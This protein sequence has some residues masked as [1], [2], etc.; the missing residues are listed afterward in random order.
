MIYRT[1]VNYEGEMPQPNSMK[2]KTSN[3]S[4]VSV[5]YTTDRETIE[6][7]RNELKK[8]QNDTAN[9]EKILKILEAIYDLVE[10]IYHKIYYYILKCD[11]NTPAQ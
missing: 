3:H 10:T 8:I 11:K 7:Y 1:T 9:K 4:K 2:K 5:S 6:Y